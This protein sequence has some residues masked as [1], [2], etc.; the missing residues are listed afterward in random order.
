MTDYFALLHEARRPWLEPE[1]LKQ[2]FLALS[3]DVHPDRVH[4]SSDAEKR[5]AQE[6]YTELNSAYNRLRDPKERLLHLLELELGAKPAQV[7][8]IPPDLMDLFMEVGQ[9]CRKADSLRAEKARTTSPLL[10]V[11]LFEAT[12]QLTLELSG[13]QQRMNSRRDE[14]IIE[15]KALDELWGQKASSS[16]LRE[17]GLLRRLEELY[18]LFSYFL[19]WSSQIQERIVQLSF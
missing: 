14:L 6:R 19:R 12:Q 16:E 18:R 8:S 7:Q 17:R 5:A 15:L 11:N 2:K 13:L 10:Q 9:L 3:A 1:A 4:G